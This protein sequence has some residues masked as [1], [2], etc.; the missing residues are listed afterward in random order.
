M[1]PLK[2]GYG[3]VV[4]AGSISR[5]DY[6]EENKLILG[7][8]PAGGIR[9]FVPGVYGGFSHI[10]ENNIRYLANLAAL[11]Q[12]YRWVRKGFFDVQEFGSLMYDGLMET[13]SAARMERLKRLKT[14]AEKAYTSASS[15]AIEQQAGPKRELSK[16]WQPSRISSWGRLSR[17]EPGWNGSISVPFQPVDRRERNRLYSGGADAAAGHSRRGRAVA[18]PGRRHPL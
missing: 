3:N 12:W 6:L 2:M 7:K 1:G 9:G 10:L 17:T 4:A 5:R 13:L 8:S 18:G 16:R 14:M 15:R 11:G